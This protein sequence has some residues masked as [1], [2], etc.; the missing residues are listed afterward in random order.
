[1]RRE[2][3]SLEKGWF[4]KLL[5][6]DFPDKTII[7]EQLVQGYVTDMDVRTSWASVGLGTD[8]SVPYPHTVNV[9]VIMDVHQKDGTFIGFML[10]LDNGFIRELSIYHIAGYDI[11]DY[12]NISFD[13][14]TYEIRI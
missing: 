10:I 5:S 9:P 7:E 11:P 6:P 2:F 12:E 14:V 3:M 8:Y 13:R 4:Q 1:M